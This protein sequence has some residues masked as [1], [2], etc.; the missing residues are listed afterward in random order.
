[1]SKRTENRRRA[2]G[3]ARTNLRL[4]RNVH[5]CLRAAIGSMRL[6]RRAGS[7]IATNETLIS[8]PRDDLTHG[9]WRFGEFFT[10][11]LEGVRTI[12]AIERDGCSSGNA[13]HTRNCG[14][15]LRG[16]PKCPRSRVGRGGG[17]SPA[18]PCRRRR[19]GR[20]NLVRL[21]RRGRCRTVA[22]W[23]RLWYIHSRTEMSVSGAR[24]RG[25]CVSLIL[26]R[27]REVQACDPLAD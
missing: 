17:V 5:G 16:S 7:A 2:R 13:E 15:P 1:M 11:D 9:G 18:R 26:D 23:F 14:Q 10:V 19:P 27:A 6:A 21:L 12:S 8:V 25:G 4:R 22:P 24:H 20:Q 3:R